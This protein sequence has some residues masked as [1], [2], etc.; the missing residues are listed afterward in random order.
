[1]FLIIGVFVLLLLILLK[2]ETSQ[3]G[4]QAFYSG[5]DWKSSFENIGNEYQKTADI[6]LAQQK[7]EWNL[8]SNLNN[9]SNFSAASFSQRGYGF[10]AFYSLAF[11]NASNITVAVGGFQG[12]ALA[13]I[14]VNMSGGQGAFFP[15]LAERQSNS[16]AFAPENA[17]NI[18]VGY[19]LN[20]TFKN[21]TFF[22][23]S[24]LTAAFY[25]SIRL[26]QADSFADDILV[27]NKTVG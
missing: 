4:R 7:T 15:S 5:L 20:N 22:A 6:S 8:E 17:F 19:Y 11:I 25:I 10:Q 18:T 13:N 23:D 21:F 9:F 26:Q 2:T 1:M 16:S 12:S 24:N 14:S 27:F 3:A